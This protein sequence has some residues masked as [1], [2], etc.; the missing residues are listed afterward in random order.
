MVFEEDIRVR[1]GEVPVQELDSELF[2]GS[3]AGEGVPGGFWILL[4][5]CG[6]NGTGHWGWR[7]GRYRI[8][9]LMTDSA[10]ELSRNLIAVWR[11]GKSLYPA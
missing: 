7:G 1:E 9:V 6:G 10:S 2:G 5:S 11:E 3:V 4:A 8:S